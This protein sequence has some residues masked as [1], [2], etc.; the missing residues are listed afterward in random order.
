[1]KHAWL[2]I[3]VG[4]IAVLLAAGCAEINPPTVGEILES[5]LGKGPLRLGMTQDEVRSL[6]GEP[7]TI[8]NKGA[9]SWGTVKEVWVYEAKYPGLVPFD[10]GH[11]TKPKYLEFSGE[12][13][14]SHH[15]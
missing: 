5:P 7:D 12:Y 6:W 2:G 3:S 1:M 8:E 9:D 4:L 11:A 13:L 14:T 15:D 10:V